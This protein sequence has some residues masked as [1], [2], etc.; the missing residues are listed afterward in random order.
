MMEDSNPGTIR[1]WVGGV[2][3]NICKNAARLGLPVRLISAVGDDPQAHI[4][5]DSCCRA[6]MDI[7][8]FLTL[9]GRSSSTYL[10][11]HS[12]EGER[13]V[14]LSEMRILQELGTDR[15]EAR[16]ELPAGAAAIV[17]D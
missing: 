5:R 15:T 17:A 13:T 16:R 2:A 14:A 9:P 8:H 11:I 12:P 1:I 3:H 10:S 7:R 6:G 4:I